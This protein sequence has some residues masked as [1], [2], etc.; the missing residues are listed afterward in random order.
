[1]TGEF[2]SE[3]TV[4]KRYADVRLFLSALKLLSSSFLERAD[5]DS[6]RFVLT[7]LLFKLLPHLSYT[8]TWVARPISGFLD[9]N[10]KSSERMDRPQTTRGL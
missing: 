8:A 6:D 5:G 3:E 10:F 7:A 2:K 4:S 1:M 9:P